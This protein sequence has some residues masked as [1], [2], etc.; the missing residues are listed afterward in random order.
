MNNEELSRYGRRFVRYFWDP[1]PRNE[2]TAPIWC[3]GQQYQSNPTPS[4]KTQ[5]PSNEDAAG[6]S[7]DSSVSVADSA[8]STGDKKEHV[9]PQANESAEQDEALEKGWPAPFIEDVESKIWMTYRSDFAAIAKSQDVKAASAMS[10]STR[11]RQLTSQDGF[12]TDTGFGCMIRS[13][14]SLLANALVT[15]QLGRDWRKGE[16]VQTEKDILS[17]FADDPSAPFSIHRFISHGAS[18]CGKQPGQW[19]GPSATARCIQILTD[20]HHP[21][22][23]RVYVRPDDSD[24]Y[25]DSFLK[26]ARGDDNTFRPTLIL[27]GTR[28]GIDRVTPVYHAALKKALEMPQSIGIAGGRPSSSHYFI[29]TQ[30][31]TFF[32][33]D[34]H[35]TR[36]R[37]PL[38]P[39]DEDV[40]TCH[41]RRLRRLDVSEM[42]PSMLLGFLIRDEDDWKSWRASVSEPGPIGPEGKRGKPIV[43]IHD[44]EPQY[45]SANV[46]GSAEGERREAVDEVE[47]CDEDDDAGM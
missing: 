5:K 28:L 27:L 40:A 9:S 31:Q 14:Q 12:T 13:G 39:S 10:W 15:I 1:L 29:G 19:F 37:L 23:L 4:P 46:S 47:S 22:N 2:D 32:Y 21:H 35:N 26:I 34:P 8:V 3:L 25:E 44:H 7:V 33:L 42:D 11:L 20:A 45:T 24:V 43:H 36:P 17:L 18:D 38:N 16:Q 30:G 6:S 41:T